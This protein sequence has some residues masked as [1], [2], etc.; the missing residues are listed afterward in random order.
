MTMKGEI[1]CPNCGAPS[2]ELVDLGRLNDPRRL[3]VEC[4]NCHTTPER[5]KCLDSKKGMR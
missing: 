2:T 5:A 4:L 1:K 3:M